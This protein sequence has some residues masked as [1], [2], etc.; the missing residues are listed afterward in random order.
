MKAKYL[1]SSE[2][3]IYRKSSVLYNL[4]RAKESAMR[5]D[6]IVLVEG[7]HGCDRRFASGRY[8]SGC[9]MWHRSRGTDPCHEAAFSKPS[10]EFRSGHRGLE[11][12]ERSIKLLL[13]ENVRVRIVELEG[14]LDPDEYCRQH[15]AE[16]Y[17][18]ADRCGQDVLLLA[19]GPCAGRGSIC[20][21]RRD[22]WMRFN[23]AAAIQG[24]GGKLERVAICE[25]SASY[26]ELNRAG[27]GA[28]PEGRGRPCREKRRS[29]IRPVPLRTYSAAP[30][31]ERQRSARATDRSFARAT[32]AAQLNTA[33][34]YELLIT[35]HDAAK[36]SASTL[37]TPACRPRIR[38][39]LPLSFSIQAWM[40]LEDGMACVEA[41][42]E[43]IWIP[44][45]AS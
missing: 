11:S 42:G 38:K 7:Y 9:F 45:A 34:I 2:T 44:F 4:N 31:H 17:Q 39:I 19:G 29:Q 41:Y 23:S 5:L 6:R 24:L 12:A 37:C 13:D 43:R 36:P 1:N 20:A 25:R 8:R 14:G 28:F 27:A 30:A 32:G 26:L 40:T 18:Q 3:K 21:I 16:A 10:S 35:M 15:G 22:A 33:P